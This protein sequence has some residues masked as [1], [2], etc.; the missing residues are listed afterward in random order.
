[1]V[2]CRKV[3]EITEFRLNYKKERFFLFYYDVLK[4]KYEHDKKKKA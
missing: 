4:V 3:A 1:M 2:R